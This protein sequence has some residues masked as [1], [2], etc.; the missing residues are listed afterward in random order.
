VKLNTPLRVALIAPA[1]IALLCYCYLVYV[2][3][4][5]PHGGPYWLFLLFL[6]VSALAC[7]TELASVVLAFSLLLRFPE[8]RSALNFACAFSGL[9]FLGPVIFVAYVTLGLYVGA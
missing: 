7:L 2:S 1:V 6:S 9:F 5:V 8:S 4:S 3:T